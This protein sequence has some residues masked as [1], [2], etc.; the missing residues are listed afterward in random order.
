MEIIMGDIYNN[1]NVTD[2]D[3][4]VKGGSLAGTC[5]GEGEPPALDGGLDGHISPIIISIF[6]LA[7]I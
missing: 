1:E 6:V 7:V 4:H 5:K 3:Y 2:Q